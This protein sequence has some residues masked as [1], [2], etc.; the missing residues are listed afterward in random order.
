LV[1]EQLVT[2]QLVAEQ[3]VTERGSSGLLSTLLPEAPAV[4]L[5]T[6]INL[7]LLLIV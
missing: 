7:T 2:K 3:S 1:T 5:T 4:T 6:N